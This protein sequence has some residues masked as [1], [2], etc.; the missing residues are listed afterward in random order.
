MKFK[1]CFLVFMLLI[2]KC[3]INAGVWEYDRSFPVPQELEGLGGGVTFYGEELAYL[4]QKSGSEDIYFM[5]PSNGFLIRQITPED[6]LR[7]TTITNN[8]DKTCIYALES[9]GAVHPDY[10]LYLIDPITGQ[11]TYLFRA[12]PYKMAVLGDNYYFGYGKRIKVADIYGRLLREFE[13]DLGSGYITGLAAS[14][15]NLLLSTNDSIF[16]VDSDTGASTRIIETSFYG[17]FGVTADNDE[18]FVTM[19][20]YIH[21]YKYYSQI[22]RIQIT[23]PKIII[24]GESADFKAEAIFND[25]KVIDV[26]SEVSWEV[27]PIEFA[28]INSYGQMSTE[29]LPGSAIVT[30][31]VEYVD[32]IKSFYGSKDIRIVRPATT[33]HIDVYNGDDA[34]SGLCAEEAFSTIQHGIDEAQDG[35]TVLIHAGIYEESIDFLGKAIVVRGL[36]GNALISGGVNPPI[37]VNAGAEFSLASLSE[38]GLGGIVF[39]NNK[40]FESILENVAVRG[41]FTGIFCGNGAPTIRNVTLVGNGYGISVWGYGNPNVRS[42]ILWGNSIADMFN[43]TADYS[44]IQDGSEGEGNIK[45]DPLFADLANGDYHLLSERGRYSPVLNRW[46]LDDVTSPC[47]DSGD[48]MY[49]PQNERMPNGGRVNMGVYGGT[50]YASMND[51]LV[52]GDINHDGQVDLI[53]LTE[54]IRDWLWVA[55]WK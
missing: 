40:G 45:S 34:N 26:T 38:P 54:V 29:Y 11:K 2:A 43:C 5:N 51:W 47:V 42:C 46:I 44:C 9:D 28:S 27:Q 32:Q 8:Q 35:D 55:D 4:A 16:L 21:V 37:T 12:Y 15:N 52:P 50:C 17:I 13:C 24:G 20:D 39:M 41:H 25:G 53:D 10:S 48:P 1:L 36:D 6:L 18:I 3:E 33:Y 31:S 23:G 49:A 14:Q 22:N 30:V 19:P 7:V